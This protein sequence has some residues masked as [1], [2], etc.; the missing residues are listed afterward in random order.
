MAIRNRPG[1]S[2]R[3]LRHELVELKEALDQSRPLIQD[4][5]ALVTPGAH[6]DEHLAKVVLRTSANHRQPHA[7]KAEAI[8]SKANEVARAWDIEDTIVGLREMTLTLRTLYENTHV[9]KILL[10]DGLVEDARAFLDAYKEYRDE[11]SNSAAYLLMRAGE[12][13]TY[14]YTGMKHVTESLLSVV[15]SPGEVDPEHAVLELE[16]PMPP[17]IEDISRFLVDLNHLYVIVAAA[18]ATDEPAHPLEVRRIE[19][20]TVWYLTV[21]GR[22]V[23]AGLRSLFR[24]VLQTVTRR[25]RAEA[26]D[27][28]IVTALH[29]GDFAEL[30]EAT[31]GNAEP[32]IRRIHESAPEI[33]QRFAALFRHQRGRASIDGEV[34]ELSANPSAQLPRPLRA[35]PPART[36]EYRR[37]QGGKVWHFCPRCSNWPVADF[38]AVD[39]LPEGVR[40][41]PEC[42]SKERRGVCR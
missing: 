11:Y 32:I 12:A 38:D 37:R 23:I 18:V 20:G 1:P 30:V 42:V 35:L 16:F 10:V 4:F 29:M 25:G 13:L 5:E 26:L 28:E 36:R 27:A 22:L 2:S 19:S 6:V 7:D 31:G 15:G 24:I 17:A 8:I 21:G 9:G 34:F 40:L 3:R 33:A 14:R 39:E 41:D